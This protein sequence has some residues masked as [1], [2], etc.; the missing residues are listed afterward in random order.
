MRFKRAHC[1]FEQSGT[2]KNEFIKLGVPAYD[3][4]ILNDFG[5]TDFQIDLFKEIDKAYEGQPSIFDGMGQEDI[6]LAFFPCIRFEAQILLH[7]RG[8]SRQQKNHTVEQKLEADLE[9]HKELHELYEHVTKLVLVAIRGG[10]KLV[11]ENPYSTQH[12]LTRYWALKPAVIDTN[13]RENGDFQIKPTQYWFVNFEPSYNFILE[14]QFVN[15]YRTHN[16]AKAR[17]GKDK[18]VMRS[19]IAPEYASRFIREFIL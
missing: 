12:Y 9:L 7:F 2:F 14:P 4:D 6:I 16:G 11:L 15:E 17:D 8:D 10:V 13:R 1:L 18:T 5:E 3:Y 19:M